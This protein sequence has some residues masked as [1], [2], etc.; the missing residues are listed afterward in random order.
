M[1][2]FS[3]TVITQDG[4]VEGYVGL[5]DGMVAEV[6]EGICP[7][8][9]LARGII[10]PPMV[11]G[12]TH[13]AD[14]DLTVPNGI[15]LC[16]LVGPDGVKE[17][18]LKESIPEKITEGMKRF[19]KLAHINGIGTFI[20][21]RE[22][23]AE[24]SMILRRAVPGAF[25]LGRPSSEEFDPN[26]LDDILRYADGIQLSGIND[27]PAPYSEAVA[28][29]AVRSGKMFAIHASEGSREDIDS[30]LALSPSFLV[31]MA[32]AERSDLLRCA[33]EDVPIVSCPRSNKFFGLTP[34]LAMMNECNNTVILGTDNAML[35]NPDMR[36]EARQYFSFL[37]DQKG[38]LENIWGAMVLN[39]RKLLY[40]WKRIGLRPGMDA[41]I[42]VLPSEDGTAG[43]MLRSSERV[44]RYRQTKKGD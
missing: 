43:G 24:G 37:T 11:N 8:E 2:Y 35:C 31:H 1:I 33:D 10:V 38:G 44:L 34:P 42:T 5:E 22:G 12:H 17:K 30:I 7:A 3:G 18:Y 21:F 25:I 16:E 13:C 40:D 19:S 9:P 41:D 4:A 15:S 28:D 29:Y 23:G 32:S 36:E 39:G 6:S 26:E 27:V 20:D 14:S